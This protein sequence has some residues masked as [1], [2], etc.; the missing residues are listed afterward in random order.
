MRLLQGESENKE[1]PIPN[2]QTYT[3]NSI[4][5]TFLRGIEENIN[6]RMTESIINL[7]NSN[8]RKIT[9]RYNYNAAF[10][11]CKEYIVICMAKYEIFFFSSNSIYQTF[12]NNSSELYIA[13]KSLIYIT[14]HKLY[15]A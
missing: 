13:S 2:I 6:Q 14:Q 1:L 15:F 12:S 9:H 4:Y 3:P 7:N 5:F 8:H 11:L 10:R